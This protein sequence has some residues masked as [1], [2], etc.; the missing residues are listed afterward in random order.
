MIS[1]HPSGKAYANF[2]EV[3]HMQADILRNFGVP[4][5]IA[6]G[7]LDKRIKEVAR[8]VMPVNHTRAVDTARLL[9]ICFMCVHTPADNHVVTFIQK[10]MDNKKPERLNDVIDILKQIPEYKE[11]KKRLGFSRQLWY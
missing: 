5:N 4:I 10:L 2:Y 3:M 11:A 8:K 9:D 6:E 7:I 1:H